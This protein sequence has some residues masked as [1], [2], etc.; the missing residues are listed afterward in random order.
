MNEKLTK[1]NR[2]FRE[3]N[4]KVDKITFYETSVAETDLNKYRNSGIAK[5]QNE[6]TD[7]EQ[8][9]VRD[10]C[11]E[12]KLG[13]TAWLIK[14]GY[15]IISQKTLRDDEV[16]YDT[17]EP[18][19]KAGYTIVLRVLAVSDLESIM[20]TIERIVSKQVA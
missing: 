6:M 3:H 18:L 7:E 8:L 4:I 2:F 15:N 5:I 14:D 20:S 12:K 9:M 10:L 16:I 1:E 17:L 11:R 13:D 19:S